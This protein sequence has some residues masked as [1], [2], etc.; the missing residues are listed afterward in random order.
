MIYQV[1]DAVNYES[2]YVCPDQATIDD[3]QAKGYTGNFIIGA[4][5]D[6]DALVEVFRENWAVAN[7]T[8]LTVNKDIDTDPVQ[9][10]WIPCDLNT[11]PANTDVDYNIF[12]IINGYYTLV[13]GLD[14]AKALLATTTE[15][16]KQ[17]FVGNPVTFETFP[18]LYPPKEQPVATGVQ[19]L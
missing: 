5:A 14:N 9:T 11:E 2:T 7:A 3:G 4:Q 18:V 16:A 13:S 15:N 6:A 8:L 1:Y 10:T 19:T 12:D 17:Y